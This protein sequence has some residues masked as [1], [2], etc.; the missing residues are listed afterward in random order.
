MRCSACS[1]DNP[2]E[3]RYCLS[4]GARLSVPCP[5]CGHENWPNAR[6][7][8]ACGASL[9]LAAPGPDAARRS[10]G[11]R[12]QATVLFADIVSST[13]LVAGLDPEQAMERLRPAVS[14]MCEAV[15][16]FDGTVVRT[17]GDG[18]MALFGAPRAQE[19]RALL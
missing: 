15:E 9:S 1:T 3:N 4:C 6:F 11:E 2:S 18:V 12:K 13:E 16:R 5:K 19:G 14:R 7:C 17:L 10:I 8:G